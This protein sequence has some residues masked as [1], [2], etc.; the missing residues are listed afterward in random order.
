MSIFLI[1]HYALT[2]QRGWVAAARLAARHVTD[3]NFYESIQ[4][5]FQKIWI[6]STQESKDLEWIDSIQFMLQMTFQ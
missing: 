2:D 1:A 3:S 6:D 4:N 5:G